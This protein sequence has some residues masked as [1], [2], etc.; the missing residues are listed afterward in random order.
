MASPEPPE[1]R[2]ACVVSG[3]KPAGR[4]SGRAL[5]WGESSVGAVVLRFV[6][7]EAAFDEPYNIRLHPTHGRAR[8][9]P[10]FPRSAV[11]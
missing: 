7:E 6:G 4:G 9:R 11:S 8:A 2:H 5:A 10:V 3:A 1:W